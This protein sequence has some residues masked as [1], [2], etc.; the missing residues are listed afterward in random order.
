MWCGQLK[1]R[2][3][4]RQKLTNPLYHELSFDYSLIHRVINYA[5]ISVWKSFS[6]NV[7]ATF[8]IHFTEYG[9]IRYFTCEF[10]ILTRWH[11]RV[12][13]LSNLPLFVLSTLFN[14]SLPAGSMISFS[15]SNLWLVFA[16]F[17]VRLIGICVDLFKVWLLNKLFIWH[18]W[19]KYMS[20]RQR[21]SGHFKQRPFQLSWNIV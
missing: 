18:L 16:G 17:C 13:L 19:A 7:F 5:H 4:T 10:Q 9:I 14:I 21:Y 12:S 3:L 6:Y 15:I 1:I 2:I 8:S 11:Y 20:Y